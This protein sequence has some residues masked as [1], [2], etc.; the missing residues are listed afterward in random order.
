MKAKTSLNAGQFSMLFEMVPTI[1]SKGVHG[2]DALFVFLQKLRT[3]LSN[4]MIGIDIGKS[5]DTVARMLR[6]ARV[7]LLEEFVPKYLNCV[8]TREK[9]ISNC[10]TLSQK[11]YHPER[12]KVLVVVDGTYI[13]IEKSSNYAFQKLTYSDH[14]KRNYIKPMIICTTNGLILAVLGPYPAINNDATIIKKIL[15]ETNP[16]FES[17]QAEDIVIVD[18]GFRDCVPEL[19]RRGLLV[20]MPASAPG[21][22]QLTVREANLSRFVT[23][24]RFIVEQVNG[25]LKGIFPYFMNRVESQ[26]VPHVMDDLQIAAAIINCFKNRLQTKDGE[27]ELALK[28]IDGLNSP[29]YLYQCLKREELQ[30]KFRQRSKPYST[31]TQLIS[32]PAFQNADE[33]KKVSL[34]IYQVNQAKS[35]CRVHLDNNEGRF[36]A[37]ILDDDVCEQFFDRFYTETNAPCLVFASIKS[38][39]VGNRNHKTYVLFD[40]KQNGCGGILGH[41]CECKNGQRTIGCCS[42]VMSIIAYFGF[43]VDHP[44]S[45]EVASHLDNILR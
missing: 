29:N 11:L 17:L 13:F 14:K 27:E 37:Q 7:A 28:M 23:I 42:H 9:L 30:K 41:Y 10:T 15:A 39:F 3:N 20:K 22:Q 16:I 6:F 12:E 32:F 34:G 19:R 31:I 35:Y 2:K 44:E 18:R 40:Q 25:Q 21:N 38:R 5:D 4:N 26:S 24:L 33:L 45:L 36:V 1:N 43:Y 8:R